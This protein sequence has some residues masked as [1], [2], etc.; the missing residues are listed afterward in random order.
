[1][2]F[3][4]IYL[5]K[6]SKVMQLAELKTLSEKNLQGF[7]GVLASHNILVETY[8][9]LVQALEFNP[10]LLEEI[11]SNHYSFAPHLRFALYASL[12]NLLTTTKRINT[13]ETFVS[14]Y[15]FPEW[16]ELLENIGG[17]ATLTA[18]CTLH[19]DNHITSASVL[20]P[21]IWYLIKQ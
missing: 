1:M 14:S 16:K 7:K 19:Y 11:E 3:F 4:F 21:Y 10:T 6:K 5:L 15:L 8:D 20:H 18:K 17:V 12:N 2:Y 13:R 9:E